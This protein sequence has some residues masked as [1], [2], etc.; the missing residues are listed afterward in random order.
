MTEDHND[1]NDTTGEPVSGAEPETAPTPVPETTAQTPTPETT[2]QTPAPEATGQA[3]ALPATTP[4][5]P[6]EPIAVPQQ[7]DTPPMGVPQGS[8]IPQGSYAM[9]ALAG[10]PM[11]GE[12]TGR[13]YA[14]PAT[15]PNAPMW[16][17]PVAPGTPATGA[18]HVRN[19]VLAGVAAFALLA[20]GV[21]IGHA[22]WTSGTSNLSATPSSGSSRLPSGSGNG[23]ANPFGNG[24]PFG[25]VFGNSGR[26]TPAT[27]T[28]ATATPARRAV[29]ARVTPAP[30]RPRSTRAS[31]TSTRRSATHRSRLPGPASCSPPTA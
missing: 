20:G 19:G 6:A 5:A 18:H 22:A 26:A 4:P 8:G 29:P 7:P 12:P 17:A 23:S 13:P 16:A 3:I 14:G 11:L 28:P 15:D 9:G 25:G 27:A 21:A 31:S 30:S 10:N 24:S 2:A 1:Q